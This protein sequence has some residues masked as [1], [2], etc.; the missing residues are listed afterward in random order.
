MVEMQSA[1]AEKFVIAAWP[2]ARLFRIAA[3]WDIDL[4]AGGCKVPS[5]LFDGMTI[6][7]IM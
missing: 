6:L 5:I 3:R 2:S 4:S 7:L 1:P